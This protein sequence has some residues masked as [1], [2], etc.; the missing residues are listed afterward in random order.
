[1]QMKLPIV[2]YP[3]SVLTTPGE[4][5][6]DFSGMSEVFADMEETLL[7]SGGIGLAAPQVGLSLR[8]IVIDE[9]LIST[10]DLKRPQHRYLRIA[11][12][13][14]V[15]ASDDTETDSEGCLSFPGL[16]IQVERPSSVYVEYKDENG[17]MQ[18]VSASGLLAR[19]LQHEIDHIDG[20]V[21]IDRLSPAD[22]M[23]AL[24][25]YRH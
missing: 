6:R 20:K 5:I 18:S 19:C 25:R 21:M 14:I 10:R 2:E 15:V 8:A 7:E 11:N 23:A 16:H 3:A 1:M 4:E 17:M 9:G 12:P 13:K 22:R 24:M